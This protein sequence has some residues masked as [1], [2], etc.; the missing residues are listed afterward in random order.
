MTASNGAS[1]SPSMRRAAERIAVHTPDWRRNPYQTLLARG[2]EGA[3]W[4]VAFSDYPE[5]AFPLSRISAAHPDAAALHL[6]W[7]APYFKPFFWSR[8][9]LK[10]R[11]KARSIQLDVLRVRLSG[12][13]V[14]WTVHNQ[15]SHETRNEAREIYLN[16]MLAEAVNRLVFH[17]EFALVKF[18]Q[19][20]G[21]RLRHK[22][23]VIPHG[24]YIGW[25][26][27]DPARTATL[28][29]RFALQGDHVVVLAF[30]AIREYKGLPKIIEAFEQARNPK[31]R[32]LIA[33]LPFNKALAEQLQAA[34]TR[35]PRILLHLGFTA[36]EEVAPLF[37][38]SHAMVLGFERVLTS[39]SA[40]LAMSLR[41]AL[42]LPYTARPLGLIEDENCYYEDSRALTSMLDALNVADLLN[43]GARN[44]L[45]AQALGWE[46]IGRE[47]AQLYSPSIPDGRRG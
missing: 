33:G 37:A 2:I 6:H 18:E 41:R 14:V 24:H 36:D 16:R 1:P 45:S 7:T 10:F 35:D 43:Q 25:Y 12:R 39:G 32:L 11:L 27:E 42:L 20:L 26:P 44:F 38:L 21:M 47:T 5:C 17:S 34:A 22:A 28:R 40:L 23:A 8:S 19:L 4:T 30:G 15:V 9:D 3:G 29:E 13:R 46:K 31:L